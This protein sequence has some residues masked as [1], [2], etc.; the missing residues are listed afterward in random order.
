MTTEQKRHTSVSEKV[1]NR[2]DFFITSELQMEILNKFT[3]YTDTTGII[4]LQ[5]LLYQK[6]FNNSW[7][8]N[9]AE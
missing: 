5:N 2:L 7:I 3:T 1:T 8:D 4:R 6:K 9:E